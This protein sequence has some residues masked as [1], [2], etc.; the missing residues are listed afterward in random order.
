MKL[1]RIVSL[2]RNLVSR[3]RVAK[4]LD[5]ELLS[6]L[7]ILTRD[8]IE[9]GMDSVEA[10]RQA[11]IEL[12][13]VEQIK[14]QVWT[15]KMGSSIQAF[16]SDIRYGLRRLAKEPT[17][18]AGVVVTVA[19]GIGATT[20]VVTVVDA[21]LLRPLAYRE[22]DRLV[23]VWENDRI[24]GTTREW[25][26][27]PD[28]FDFKA[29]SRSFEQMGGYNSADLTLTPSD[30]LP[31]KIVA[32][33]ITHTLFPMFGVQPIAGR[34]FLQEED[35]PGGPQVMMIS[36]NL[37]RRRF[38]S[39]PG[40]V[41]ST[42]KVDGSDVV[43]VGIMPRTLRFPVPRVDAWIPVQGSRS[44][45]NPGRHDFR[46]YGRLRVGVSLEVVQEELA[47]IAAGLEELYPAN[48]IGRGVDVVWMQEDMTGGVRPALLV[49]LAAVA[50]VLL[51]ACANVA[52][53][54][55]A[56]SA[57]RN[58][59][60]AI[61]RALG[62]RTIQ[63][64]RQLLAESV[65]L[66]LLG[67]ALGTALAYG[68]LRA[69]VTLDVGNLP[70]AA[71]I[72]LDVRVLLFTLLLSV[73]T[74]LLFGLAPAWSAARRDA[75]D[76]L[77]E[78][79]RPTERGGR[80]RDILVVAEIAL[81]VLLVISAGLL[82]RSFSALLGVDPGFD[83]ANLTKFEFLLPPIRYP[84]SFANS[85]NSDP[86]PAF[87][88]ELTDRVRRLPGVDAVALAYSH[89]MDS[90]FT[91][92][93]FVGA[94]APPPGQGEEARIRAVSVDYFL[95]LEIPVIRGRSFDNR[96]RPEA[97]RVMV[98]NEAFQRR[99]IPD[100]DPIGKSVN[101]FGRPHEVV[102]IVAD[103]KFLGLDTA[104]APALYPHIDQFSLGYFS[105]LV[106]SGVG[107]EQLIPAVQNQ[108]REMDPQLAL[109]E[110]ETMDQVF[111]NSV[112]RPRF[113]TW[114]LGSFAALALGLAAV[115]VYGIVAY[116][117]ARRTHEIG[118]RMALGAGRATVVGMVLKQGLWL[119][120]IRT[121]VGLVGAFALT[122]LMSGLLFGIDVTDS[123][124]FLVVSVILVGVA[125]IASYVPAHRATRVDPM[126]ALRY[127]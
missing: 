3:E 86:V 113:N 37:W 63:L 46:V 94:V 61:R 95:T 82:I 65:I 123:A 84:L 114:L 121:A 92:S 124:T 112:S 11:A 64:V 108:V 103:V 40:M 119:G 99:Y 98:I 29:E 105:L 122:R 59:E 36:E 106:R 78:G 50:V 4:L 30:G 19:L 97:L 79:G 53:L 28:Y 102:G 6:S 56:Q 15:A 5:E 34:G 22:P 55:L 70:R 44:T 18:T 16:G 101:V 41:G 71:E 110:I 24:N 33:S 76:T 126:N 1:S 75:N 54:L 69:L 23:R 26:S 12:G 47:A 39:D 43:V 49:F 42:L 90:G 66:S 20:A 73:G 81:A 77:K 45:S 60:I 83:S 8:K 107:S 58:K 52:S 48:N 120:A 93:F 115:G 31:A 62:A 57:A 111:R 10:R 91:S 87:Q 104:V 25:A 100:E 74:G 118:V 35:V 85:Q 96:D 21:I 32:Y 2:F 38:G 7:D 51:I 116:S 68:A 72:A 67:G 13:G 109:S 125:L 89:P 88:A 80:L 117:V 27:I 17:F 14:E 9:E 127:E